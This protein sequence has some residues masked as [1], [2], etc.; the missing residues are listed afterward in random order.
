MI[1]K[2]LAGAVS[3]SLI[4]GNAWAAGCV[5]PDDLMA[6]KTSSMQQQLMVA[7]FSCNDVALYNRF[8]VGHQ[9]ELQAADAALMAFFVREN[10]EGGTDAYH[11][12]KTKAANVSA[13]ESARDQQGYCARAQQLFNAALDPYG[14]D[15]AWFVSSQWRA[16]GEFIN[17]TCTADTDPSAAVQTQASAPSG[18]APPVPPSPVEPGMGSGTA[19]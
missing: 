7:A 13:L 1:R 11:A 2:I 17:A 6:M 3:L 14:A 19:D 16:T 8:V 15:L 5:G 9:H 10:A 18:F 4:A 12:F